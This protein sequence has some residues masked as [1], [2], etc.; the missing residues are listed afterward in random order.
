MTATLP[1]IIGIEPSPLPHAG[2]HRP[3]AVGMWVGG[4]ASKHTR[5]NYE[6]GARRMIALAACAGAVVAGWRNRL[7][8]YGR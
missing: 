8:P 1:A 4:H 5:R 3:R 6:R 7:A 2:R